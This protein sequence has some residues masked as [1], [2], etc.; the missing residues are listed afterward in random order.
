MYRTTRQ[1]V[2]KKIEEEQHYKTSKAEKRYRTQ[3]L[4]TAEYVYFFFSSAYGTL[5][6]KK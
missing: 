3:H 6:D 4:T 2:N 5:K 1:K